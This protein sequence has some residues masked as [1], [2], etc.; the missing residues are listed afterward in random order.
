MRVPVTSTDEVGQLAQ[1]FN[2]MATG[3]GERKRLFDAFGAYVDPDV[4]RRVIE[5][6]VDLGGE[7][8]EVT[9]MFIDIRGFTS[10]AERSSARDV[11]TTLN[12]Y[13]GCVV[14][15]VARHGGYANKFLGDGL[16]AVFGAPERRRDH[17]DRAVAAALE[18]A[19]LVDERY[20]D[21]LRVGIG[22][23]SGPVVAGTMGGGGRVEFTVIGDAV[24]TAARV[25]QA[26]RTTGDTVLITQATEALLTR[27]VGG[28]VERPTMELRG[29]SEQVRLL[30]PRAVG[31]PATASEDGAPVALEDALRQA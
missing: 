19:E 6:G 11:V 22:V 24:N 2:R 9:V 21:G 29:K 18:L 15:V 26:T 1:S 12:E 7:E 13:F 25:E 14:P 23:N 10:F 27:D 17:A 30:A 16:L 20:G 28:F 3:L 31:A 8:V 5:E 4:G